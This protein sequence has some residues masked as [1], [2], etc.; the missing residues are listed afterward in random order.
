MVANIF[1]LTLENVQIRKRG[2]RLLGPVSLKIEQAGF[3]AVMGP[4][5]A[6]KT[7][8]LRTLHGMERLSD[9]AMSWAIDKA[10]AQRQQAFVFQT[11]TLMRRTT[12]EN[13]AFPLRLA[14]HSAAKARA[15]AQ[16]WL[17]QVGLGDAALRRASVLSGGERQKMALARALITKPQ[18]LFLDEPCANLDG[19]ATREIESLLQQAHRAGT[20]ILLATHDLGQARRLSD[21]V[22]FLHRGQIVERRD[23]KTFFNTPSS[24]EAQAYINGDIV[25]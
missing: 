16:T 7:T 1:P 9:G 10:D 21:D 19:A 15:E 13:V 5:G 8:L 22:L 4:N 17:D 12:L 11:P 14:G 24:P 2:K 25:E 3:T 20:R 18:A 6:G 23:T